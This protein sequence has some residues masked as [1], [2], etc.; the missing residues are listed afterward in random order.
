M[1][2]YMFI[3]TPILFL[4]FLG[5]QILFFMDLKLYKLSE[6]ANINLEENVV[7]EKEST[8]DGKVVERKAGNRKGNKQQVD[9]LLKEMEKILNIPGNKRKVNLF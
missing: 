5:S 4:I 7:K 8:N 3:L 1:L 9:Y 6:L 2:L